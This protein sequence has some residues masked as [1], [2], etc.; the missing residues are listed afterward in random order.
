MKNFYLKSQD[1]PLLHEN[2]PSLWQLEGDVEA[3][4]YRLAY[5]DAISQNDDS[6]FKTFNLYRIANSPKVTSRILS[7]QSSKSDIAVHWK[8]QGSLDQLDNN[9][10]KSYAINDYSSKFLIARNVVDF[11]VSFTCS[12]FIP[13][14]FDEERFFTLPPIDDLTNPQNTFLRVGGDYG[15]NDT[16]SYSLPS[17]I[18]RDV[19][20]YPTAIEVSI[21]LLSEAGMKVF[22]GVNDG[23]LP[24][25]R[26]ENLGQLIE[27][28]GLSFTRM[29]KLHRQI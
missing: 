3:V 2:A 29:V 11:R 21:T 6:N 9:E 10:V 12:C 25:D 16:S 22:R 28:H 15:T 4:G 19:R 26:A 1:S 27:E 18:P 13:N 17:I 5:E 8:G 24:K 23:N 7:P 20:V 14:D